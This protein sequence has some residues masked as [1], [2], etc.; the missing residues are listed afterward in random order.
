MSGLKNLVGVPTIGDLD[1]M[2]ADTTTGNLGYLTVTAD[3]F[4]VAVING[5]TYNLK[6]V[7]EK[8]KL[9]PTV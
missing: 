3:G 7:D 5:N 4:F 6:I 1:E 9:V 8:V 2:K